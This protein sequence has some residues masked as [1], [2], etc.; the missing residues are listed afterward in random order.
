MTF[1]ASCCVDNPCRCTTIILDAIGHHS[2]PHA[3]AYLSMNHPTTDPDS[4]NESGTNKRPQTWPGFQR[5]F[6]GKVAMI[7]GVSDRGIGGAIAERLMREGAALAVS[8]LDKPM[9]LLKRLDRLDQDAIWSACD[10]TS[11]EQVRSAIDECMDEFGKIDLLVN[12][13]GVE[14]AQPLE[15]LTSQQWQAVLDVNLGGAI[16][17]TQV[18]LP[19]LSGPGGCIVNIGS[20]LGL[21]GCAGYAVYSASKAGLAGFTRSM[22][23]ELAPRRIRCVC[24]APALVETPMVFKHLRHLTDEVKEHLKATH[25][26]GTGSPHDV[27]AAAAFLGSADARWITGITMP[28][29]WVEHYPLPVN[30]F[31]E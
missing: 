31:L 11:E 9:R 30:Q 12:N 14:V 29:G 7:T 24:L 23:I 1:S 3:F 18:A 28:M 25:P 27:A 5:R 26:L 10:V 13:A 2:R 21:A 20:T 19:Y 6:E 17:V 15:N 16:R 22:A 8:S 4:P